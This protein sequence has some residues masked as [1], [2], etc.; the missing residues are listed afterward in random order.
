MDN[1]TLRKLAGLPITE[2]QQRSDKAPIDIHGKKLKQGDFVRARFED[3]MHFAIFKRV[4]H[5]DLAILELG[6]GKTAN[7]GL[8]HVEKI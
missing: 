4:H 1:I 2:A 8:D 5:G 7:T 3:G 6:S